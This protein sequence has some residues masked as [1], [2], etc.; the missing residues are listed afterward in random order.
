[1]SLPTGYSSWSEFALDM[2][3]GAL[4]IGTLIAACALA[5]LAQGPAP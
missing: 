3:L 2:V 1:M 4:F 5:T